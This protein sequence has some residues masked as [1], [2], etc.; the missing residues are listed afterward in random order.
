[1]SVDQYSL[2]RGVAQDAV[3][4]LRNKRGT[5]ADLVCEKR[6]E[7]HTQ[8]SVPYYPTLHSIG[9]DDGEMALQNPL[10]VLPREENFAMGTTDYNMGRWDSMVP[11]DKAILKD[12]E[13][14]A[15]GAEPLMNQIMAK[16]D[17]KV[18]RSLNKV[19]VDTSS[20]LTQAV[21]A[22]YWS[23]VNSTPSDDILKAYN[24]TPGANLC[25]VGLDVAQNLAKH[26]E[27]KETT[28]NYSGTGYSS[29]AQV[30]AYIA[31]L[32]GIDPEQVFIAEKFYNSANKGQ[33]LTLAYAFSKTFWIGH[34]EGLLL[35]E[36]NYA[37][38]IG[39]ERPTNEGLV[40]VKE[41]HNIIEFAYGRVGQIKRA[42]DKE[43]GCVIPGVLA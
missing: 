13:K 2:V 29:H 20:N 16:A 3:F 25:V 22:S 24:Q 36:Q 23:L 14:F 9:D 21:G 42:G 5:V 39:D 35:I 34:R 1:M 37:D 17:L 43:L 33:T 7:D 27:F 4:G 18:D 11:V 41:N 19:L 26:P 38:T 32:T 31:E 30:R 15:K 40:T 8:G 10:G 28:S 12:V 6:I